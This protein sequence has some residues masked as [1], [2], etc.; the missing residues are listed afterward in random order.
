MDKLLAVNALITPDGTRLQSYSHH[1]YKEYV[2]ANGKTYMVDGGLSYQ[3]RSA[4]GDEVDA[5]LY[6]HEDDFAVI[7]DQVT[8]G[9]YGKNGDQPLRYV[10]VS[11]MSNNHIHALIDYQHVHPALREVF[12]MERQYRIENNIKVE[13]E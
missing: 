5:S 2:D 13:D 3:R 6:L 11:E 1:D 10:P 8:W 12:L 4:H 9:T 7:R